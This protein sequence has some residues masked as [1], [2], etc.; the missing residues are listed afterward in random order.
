MRSCCKCLHQAQSQNGPLTESET[1]SWGSKGKNIS[2]GNER[3]NL[4]KDFG[5]SLVVLTVIMM[6][7]MVTVVVIVVVVL[8]V[9]WEM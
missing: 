2:L 8:V 4:L 1:E 7:M 3:L 9:R 5:G 6:M